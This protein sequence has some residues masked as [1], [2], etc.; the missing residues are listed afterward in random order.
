MREY[1]R[2]SPRFWVGETGREIR[3]KGSD[4]QLLA[5]YLMTS[6]HSNMIGMYWCPVAYMAHET[7]MSFEGASKALQSLVDCSFCT[8]DTSSEVVWVTEMASYQVGEC[9]SEKDNQVKGVQKVYDELPKNPFLSMFYERYGQPFRMANRR[10][11]EPPSK[12]LASKEKEQEK[13]TEKA[14]EKAVV[15][16]PSGDDAAAHEMDVYYGH[17]A[18]QQQFTDADHGQAPIQP[19][20]PSK[21]KDQPKTSPTWDA[22][23]NA[24]FGRY[25][26]E[27]VRNATINGQLANFVNRIGVDEAPHVAAYYVQHNGRFYVSQMHPVGAMTKD[28]E[29]L[30]TEWATGRQ[31]TATKAHQADKTQTNYDAFAGLRAEAEMRERGMQ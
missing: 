18:D 28:A 6:P 14:Q 17:A 9:L 22:Y 1:A 19:R 5:L 12:P 7:G 26:T 3:S 31:M 15:A 27:P 29:K 13:A 21:P 2:V 20:K 23:A 10:H 16:T 25:G 4:A 8:Y 11:Y 30:R 24:Y